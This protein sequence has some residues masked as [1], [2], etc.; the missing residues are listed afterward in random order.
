MFAFLVWRHC[1][2]LLRVAE[3]GVTRE[4]EQPVATPHNGAGMRF[5]GQA[6]RRDDALDKPASSC[7]LEAPMNDLDIFPFH[8]LCGAYQGEGLAIPPFGRFEVGAPSRGREPKWLTGLL[9]ASGPADLASLSSNSWA[10]I[11]LGVDDFARLDLVKTGGLSSRVVRFRSGFVRYRG[12]RRTALDVFAAVTSG[13]TSS[14]LL[15]LQDRT[16]IARIGTY[17]NAIAGDESFA[18][19]GRRGVA[20]CGRRGL[21]MAG[22]G[23]TAQAA[24]GGLAIVESGGVA[25][26]GERGVVL[27]QTGRGGIAVAGDEGLALSLAPDSAVQGG[28]ESVVVLREGG[29]S[30]SVG[31]QGIGVSAGSVNAIDV[32]DGGVAVHAAPLVPGALFRLGRDALLIFQVQGAGGR[33]A[34]RAL[35]PA[36]EDVRAGVIHEYAVRGI[37]SREGL[38]QRYLDI[39]ANPMEEM[40]TVGLEPHGELPRLPATVSA[41]VEFATQGPW[42]DAASAH[43]PQAWILPQPLEDKDL[44]VLTRALPAAELEAG[45]TDGGWWLGAPWGRGDAGL[46]PGAPCALVRVDGTYEGRSKPSGAIAFRRGTAFYRGTLRGALAALCAMGRDPQWGLRLALAGS[47]GI[48]RVPVG[49]VEIAPLPDIVDETERHPL[50][51]AAATVVRGDRAIGPHPTLAIAGDEGW[52][53]SGGE[54]HAGRGGFACVFGRGVARAGQGGLAIAERGRAVAGDGGIAWS[55]PACGDAGLSRHVS[56]GGQAEAG[57]LGVAIAG[58]DGAVATTQDRGIS[59]AMAAGTAHCGANGVAVGGG[60]GAVQAGGGDGAVVVARRGRV[61]GKAGTLLVAQD[62]PSG[63]WVWGVVGENGIAPD[64]DY[65]ASKGR[66]EP[67]ATTK[68]MRAPK[69]RRPDS[70]ST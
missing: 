13:A 34:F 17:G 4:M 23:G 66:L 8:V 18:R 40:P 35:A 59:V 70:R 50:Q 10:V 45:R 22:D 2:P 9:E 61:Q 15:S 42:W 31:P 37:L 28:R 11:E 30:M 36:S 26:A 58:L 62:E 19:A 5:G 64:T 60:A 67:W 38:S 29:A 20:T 43:D 24:D 25:R 12:E 46:L 49:F 47:G 32:H 33:I 57:S 16:G 53:I 51:A 1:V 39:T 68:A 48:A 6:R 63:R 54:A 69:Q 7:C 27:V 52:A 21:A 3:G 14:A 55:R 65:I 44:V 56:G 41:A